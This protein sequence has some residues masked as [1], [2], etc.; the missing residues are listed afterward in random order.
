MDEATEP[1]ATV[2]LS[3]RR[4]LASLVEFGRPEF[5]GAVEPL[6]VVVVDIGAEHEFEMAAVDDQQ[7]VRHLTRGSAGKW[8]EDEAGG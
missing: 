8:A 1:V 3:P 6:A 5:E 4:S 2:D 7:P